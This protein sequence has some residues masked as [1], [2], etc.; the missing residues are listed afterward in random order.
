MMGSMQSWLM[1]RSVAIG[2]CLDGLVA[3]GLHRAINP[4]EPWGW[5]YILVAIWVMAVAIGLRRWAY[6]VIAT[7]LNKGMLA[8]AYRRQLVQNQI[9]PPQQFDLDIET[10]LNQVANSPVNTDSVRLRAAALAQEVATATPQMGLVAGLI[11][12]M[13]LNNALNQLKR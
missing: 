11:L 4:D 3:Y 9:P 12:R 13:S 7:Y 6:R 8:E 1:A 10:H 5:A 2:A